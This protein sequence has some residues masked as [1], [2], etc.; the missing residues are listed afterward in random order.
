[1]SMGHDEFG[2]SDPDYKNSRNYAQMGPS[3]GYHKYSESC[4]CFDC[5]KQQAAKPQRSITTEETNNA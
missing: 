1:M 2:F 4:A 3:E 5:M